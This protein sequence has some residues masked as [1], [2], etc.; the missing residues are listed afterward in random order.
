MLPQFRRDD[1]RV[2]ELFDDIDKLRE[3]FDSIER[4]NLEIETP[5][6]KPENESREEVQSSVLEP[7]AEGS[8]NSKPETGKQP[9]PKLPADK[10]E[11]TL[12]AA[13]ELAKLESEFGKVSHDYSAEEIG[14]W[15]FDE[16][17]SEL[18]SGD[19]KN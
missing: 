2:K 18:R 4:P 15:E 7:P 19:S 16:L 8:K 6:P 17:E 12:D 5:P 10:A 9:Q 14:E 1:S 11:Q 3:K 13:A